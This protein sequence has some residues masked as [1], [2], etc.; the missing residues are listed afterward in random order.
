[1][2]GK[3][4]IYLSFA[5]SILGVVSFFLVHTGKEKYLKPAR[6]FYLLTAT[7]VITT[8]ALLMYM[9]L[10]HQ[11]QYSYV[12]QQSNRELGLALLISTFYA[13]QEGSFMLWTLMTAI[14]GIFLLRY[15]SKGDRLEPEVMSV[16]SLVLGF[17]TFILILKSPF[18]YV[19]DTY[20][21][22]VA[23][24]F[25]PADGRGLNPLLQNF[26][27]SIHP[28]T[29][30]VG[31]SAMAVPFCFAIGTLI[32]NKYDEWIS[33]SLPWLLFAGG[34]LVLGIML[35]GYWAYGVLGWG[36]YWAWDP[37]EN[38]SLIP[39]III[40]A[41]IH[42]MIAQKRTGGYKK[43]NLILCILS[44]LLVLYS[45]FLT[46][47][48][49]LGDSSVHS[50]VDPGKEVYISLVVFMLTFLA[51]GIGAVIYRAKE[52]KTFDSGSKNILTR[53]SALFVGAVT[54]CAS[55]LVVFAG[56]SWPIIASGSIEQ[57]F[58]NKMNL[59]I[60]ILISF[61]NGMSLLLKWKTND[62]K[63]FFKSLLF[64]LI[65]TCVITFALVIVGVQDFIFA[66]F[67]FAAI[68][69]FFVNAEIAI[70]IFK[71]NKS[72]IG[73]YVAHIGLSLF[74]LGI[75]ASSR[76]SQ[77]VNLTLELNK[78]VEAFGYR[79]T[80]LG[81]TEFEDPNNQTDSKYHFNIRVQ[82]DGKELLL[83]PV[84]YF[85]SFSEGV[86]KN[87]DIANFFARDL[88][89]S[90]M[91]LVEPET[92]TKDQIHEI[93]K[94]K[95]KDIGALNVEFI[96]FNFGGILP[97]GEEVRSGNFTVGAKLKVSD[98]KF[99]EVIEPK[100]EY[101]NGVPSYFVA[102]MSD[103]PNL[104]FYFAKMNVSNTGNGEA[105][106]A[107]IAIVNTDETPMHIPEESLVI[108]ASIKP[109]INILWAG[110]AILVIGF[111]ISIYRRRK[112][113]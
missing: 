24:G 77:D 47:S 14:I 88:Y 42:T 8:S 54:L 99:S 76:Y 110:T 41:A 108:N 71:K 84:M 18:N 87:P 78:P 60:A 58:Y 25:I 39:W 50:F 103:K 32:K 65:I 101:K 55:A 70:T 81:A 21:G 48:G 109:F 31:F 52:L 22:D 23:P 51:I 93:P 73:A 13:G 98:N 44:Y 80:Y 67:A 86:M 38:S 82:Q 74:F 61:I 72:G 107:S 37:V 100:I 69:A 40:V 97:G 3:I 6:V 46:R 29:L 7:F 53:E 75:I 90:P 56:T 4:L 62:E 11:F 96:D 17:L 9:I 20:A 10:T 30:F 91:G 68:F 59:P 83:K 45:T 63:T 105:P 33:Y 12:W 104:N 27:M 95:S 94:G 112:D 1:M 111:F 36:G 5:F 66:L 15:V 16:Y 79:L 89:L 92:F 34:V 35:G 19:W 57:D 2:V 113:L 26:W 28:P 49:V 64:P 85:S 43:T 106:T 102:K